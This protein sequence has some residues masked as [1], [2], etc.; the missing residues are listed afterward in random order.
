MSKIK[1]YVDK[2][3]G[4]IVR[5]TKV[6]NKV[7]YEEVSQGQLDNYEI[8]QGIFGCIGAIAAAIFVL[9]LF[10]VLFSG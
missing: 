7:E 4:K 1:H 3:S 5:E 9:W 10:A 8:G 2:D 6:G